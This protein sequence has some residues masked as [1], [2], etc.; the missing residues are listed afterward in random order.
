M[1][2]VDRIAPRPLEDELVPLGN[3]VVDGAT[4]MRL[5]ERS[6]AVHAARRLHRSLHLVVARVVDLSPVEHALQ[7]VPVRVRVAVVIDEAACLIDVSKR[8]VTALDF[9]SVVGRVRLIAPDLVV[10]AH[11][12]ASLLLP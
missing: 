12:E 1:Q 5:T 4:C 2:V 7:G 9:G 3:E 8:A 6:T 10:L 11:S